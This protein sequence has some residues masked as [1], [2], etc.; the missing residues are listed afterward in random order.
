MKREYARNEFAGTL[1]PEAVIGCTSV[2]S[3]SLVLHSVDVL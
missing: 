2:E 1:P 3:S